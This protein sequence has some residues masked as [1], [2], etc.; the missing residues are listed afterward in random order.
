MLIIYICLIIPLY[1]CGY[2][3]GKDYHV[4]LIYLFQLQYYSLS[5]QDPFHFTRGKSHFPTNSCYMLWS[6]SHFYSLWTLSSESSLT[7]RKPRAMT[8]L[9]NMQMESFLCWLSF[10]CTWELG[11]MKGE[12]LIHAAA[13]QALG[14]KWKVLLSRESMLFVID[15]ELLKNDDKHETCGCTNLT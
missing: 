8:Q 9:A 12:K 4:C 6:P 5:Q 3:F 14:D 10:T 2:S 1:I 11:N 7:I 15:K 13:L